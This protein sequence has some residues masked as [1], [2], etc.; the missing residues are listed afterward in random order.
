MA[1][2]LPLLIWLPGIAG[3]IWVYSMRRKGI[4]EE[5]EPFPQVWMLWLL[6]F[7]V[8]S[9]GL[10]SLI[11]S[12]VLISVS[13]GKEKRLREE[14]ERKELEEI[15]RLKFE[16]L[17]LREKELRLQMLEKGEDLPENDESSQDT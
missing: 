12:G 16:L 1:F 6:G 10:F 11:F 13:K 2:L 17:D 15:G 7:S 14:K 8:I 4:R 3:W 9:S 5:Q